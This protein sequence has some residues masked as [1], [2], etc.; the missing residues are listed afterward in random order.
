MGMSKEHI[1][2]GNVMGQI[3]ALEVGEAVAFNLSECKY[4]TIKSSCYLVS[5]NLDRRYTTSKHTS[6]LGQRIVVVTR[7]S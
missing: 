3:R 6:G 2:R 1:T 4:T 7:M 5:Q